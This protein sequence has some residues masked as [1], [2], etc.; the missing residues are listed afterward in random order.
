MALRDQP[1]LPLYV[2]DFLTDEKLAECSAESNGVYI[3]IMCLMHKSEEYG[4]ILLQQKYKQNSSTCLN[5][6]EKLVSHLPYKVDVI[7][8]S[9]EELVETGV[10][11]IDGDKMSQRR[12]VR[13]FAVSNARSEAGQKGG[14]AKANTLAKGVANTLANTEYEYESEIEDK[15]K[16]KKESA[17]RK[18]KKND[19]F[20][21]F[22]KFYAHY[23][24]KTKRPDAERA[25][26][27]IK[28]SE[29]LFDKIM[30]AL[31]GFKSSRDWKKDN[32]QFIPYPA[33][34]LNGKQWEDDI[35]KENAQ[36]R[37]EL[38]TDYC[39]PEDWLQ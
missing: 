29:E 34:W 30:T 5:F 8:R 18:Q 14:F 10:L 32:G 7:A 6:A 2:Q 4:T 28:M 3:R 13:D 15:T 24:R 9:L 21:L 17:E 33:T 23:P 31:D 25:F 22:D 26:N 37:N 27:K 1:Y 35:P 20:T 39:A 11:T 19:T 12:M 16:S 36:S 38:P